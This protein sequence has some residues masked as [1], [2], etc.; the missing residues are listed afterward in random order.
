MAR[1][2]AYSCDWC[3]QRT[4]HGSMLSMLVFPID[5]MM[6]RELDAEI[7]NACFQLL[8]NAIQRIAVK[9]QDQRDLA[10]KKD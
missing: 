3:E 7:C 1:V 6:R 10:A 4:P 2:T 5:K 8:L 9:A